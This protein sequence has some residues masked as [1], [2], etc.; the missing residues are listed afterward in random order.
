MQ[1]ELWKKAISKC[2]SM[3]TSHL[4]YRNRK[5][6]NLNILCKDNVADISA[7]KDINKALSPLSLNPLHRCF[8]PSRSHPPHFSTSVGTQDLER[9]G[10]WCFFFFPCGLDLLCAAKQL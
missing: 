2:Q 4:I 10:W 7:R 1:S 5:C 9:L 3:Q 6:K 8:F